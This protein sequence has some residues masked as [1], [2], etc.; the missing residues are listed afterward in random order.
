MP[1]PYEGNPIQD[2]FDEHTKFDQV[3]DLTPLSPFPKREGGTKRVV[4]RIMEAGTNVA[5]R[6]MVF[7]K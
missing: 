1:C 5:V 3:S 4:K 7:A 2:S 6:K